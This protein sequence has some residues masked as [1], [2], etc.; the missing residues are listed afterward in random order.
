MPV[1]ICA[2]CGASRASY[3]LGPSY[4]LCDTCLADMPR[5]VKEAQARAKQKN[6]RGTGYVSFQLSYMQ[7]MVAGSDRDPC[8]YCGA[9]G[10]TADH[11]EPRSKGGPNDVQNLAPA[12]RKCNGTKG[13]QSLLT[14]L[15]W[16]TILNEPRKQRT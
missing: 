11:I 6:P 16:E 13:S 1:G 5:V 12:C 14:F 8:V 10:V 15:L 2:K 4:L 7:A 3:I 9:P